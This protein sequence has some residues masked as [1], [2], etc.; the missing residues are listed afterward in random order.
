MRARLVIDVETTDG[1]KKAGDI[2]AH[3]D[4]YRLV[5]M[6]IAEPA[7]DYCRKR[8]GMTDAQM[9]DAQRRYKRVVTGEILD[10]VGTGVVEDD[11][12]EPAEWY[13]S[14]IDE[15][16]SDVDEEEPTAEGAD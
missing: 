1:P 8:A 14:E 11:A 16:E 15:D 6:G 4:A 10:G 7:D 3:D 13:E 5:Q 2:V 9:A 12:A